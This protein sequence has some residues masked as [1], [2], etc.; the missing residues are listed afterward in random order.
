MITSFCFFLYSLDQVIKFYD[1]CIYTEKMSSSVAPVFRPSSK[2]ILQK[3]VLRNPSICHLPS[4]RFRIQDWEFFYE[5]GATVASGRKLCSQTGQVGTLQYCSSSHQVFV[6]GLSATLIKAVYIS[7]TFHEST[8]LQYGWLPQLQNLQTCLTCS[9][10]KVFA[11]ATLSNA[12][13]VWLFMVMKNQKLVQK[14]F[15]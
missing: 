10:R 3:F 9:R 4:L 13:K 7:L 6:V 14:F 15:N 8:Q 2:S 5:M 1:K 11:T 12:C